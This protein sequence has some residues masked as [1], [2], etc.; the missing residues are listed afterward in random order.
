MRKLIDLDSHN[1]KKEDYVYSRT[2]VRAIIYDNSFLYMIKSKK[3]G[4]YKFPGGGM[5][6]SESQVDTLKREVLEESGIIICDDIKP[7]GYVVEKR[8]SYLEEDAIFY[9]ISYYYLCSVK[10]FT[11]TQNLDA[12]EEEYGYELV[13]VHIDEAIKTNHE[14]AQRNNEKYAWVTREFKV[15]EMIKDEL[16]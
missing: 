13:R 15:L 4:E 5:E 12:Y 14:L 9:M 16:L 2:A 3:Y 6:T 8:K 7:Y 10:E 1:Y 11:D